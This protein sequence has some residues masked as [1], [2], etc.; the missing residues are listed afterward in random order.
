MPFDPD[1]PPNN[2]QVRAAELRGQFQGL[3]ALIDAVPG[4]A[5]AL[6]GT[7]STLPPGSSATADLQIVSGVLVLNLGL[8]QGQQGDPGATG[9]PGEV[10]AND[11]N[12]A[13]TTVTNASSA[14]SNSVGT[15]SQGADASYN[16]AQIQAL[17]D[18][19]DELINALRR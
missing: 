15:L 2:V 7:V 8:P 11:L 12:N 3:K 10:T 6:I 9:Q 4:V 5:S 16:P 13:V 14:N 1:I 17:L 19:V 18:K